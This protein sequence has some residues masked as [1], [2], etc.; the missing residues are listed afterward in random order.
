VKGAALT[1][2]SEDAAGR[3]ERWWRSADGLR[4]HARDYA[5]ASGEAKLPVVL[6]HGLTRN[7]R[8][9]EDLAP[10]IASWGRRVV[11][12]DVRGRG[13]SDR[14]PNPA[15]YHPGLYAAD[16]AGLLDRLGVARAQFLG[17]SM[18]G[19]IT[20]ALSTFRGELIA[21]AVL[22]D[23]GPV[24]APE[25]L[26]RISAYVGQPAEAADWDAA[27]AY[28][29]ANNARAL[30]HYDDAA[31]ARMARRLFREGANGRPELDYDLRIADAIRATAGAPA[32]D[33]WPYFDALATGRPL[34]V[35]RGANS[36][37]LDAQTAA[38]MQARAPH[39]VLAE[40]PGV[41]HAPMLD[42]PVALAAIRAHLDAVA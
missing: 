42:E 1:S 29:K 37:L 6:V 7:S 8:D 34:L 10:V 16:I 39:T 24:I 30:P 3:A 36:D 27:A 17:T 19:L 22:N 25:G 31:W 2:E 32:P 38:A 5:A 28:V 35:V 15:N 21:G 18:G 40:V 33:L 41:G 14:D 11:V 12:P 9:F 13:R 4:L 23:V 20:M 26:G